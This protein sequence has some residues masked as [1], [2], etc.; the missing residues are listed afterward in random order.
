MTLPRSRFSR[1]LIVAGALAWPLFCFSAL[2]GNKPGDALT[3]AQAVAVALEH[4]HEIKAVQSALAAGR[5][6]IGIARS[7]LLPRIS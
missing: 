7:Y 1:L 6:D 5:A 3:M 4:N 2:A